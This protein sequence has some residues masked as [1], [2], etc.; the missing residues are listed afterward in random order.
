MSSSEAAL[1]LKKSAGKE[2]K[3]TAAKYF[4]LILK[5]TRHIVV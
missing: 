1:F 3:P 2:Q 5:L 4:D